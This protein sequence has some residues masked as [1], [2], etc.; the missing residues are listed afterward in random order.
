MINQMAVCSF[1]FT[2]LWLAIQ[3]VFAVVLFMFAV[4]I[5][6]IDVGIACAAI[7][8]VIAII[9]NKIFKP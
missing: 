7:V 2:L 1:V 5:P 8:H 6:I 3:L 9:V 4:V